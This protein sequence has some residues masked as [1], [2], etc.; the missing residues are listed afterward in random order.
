METSLR[1]SIILLI[2]CQ[3]CHL[4]HLAINFHANPNG[5]Y[6]H[7]KFSHCRK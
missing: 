3:L 7:L 4:G 5:M 6:T 1:A 2:V